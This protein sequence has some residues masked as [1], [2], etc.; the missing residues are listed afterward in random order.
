MSIMIFG[1]FFAVI[2]LAT[3]KEVS[4]CTFNLRLLLNAIVSDVIV[5]L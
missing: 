1:P 3:V 4:D 5:A 2:L